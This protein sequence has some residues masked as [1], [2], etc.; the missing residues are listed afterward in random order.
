MDKNEV[1]TRLNNSDYS[2]EFWFLNQLVWKIPFNLCED[3]VFCKKNLFTSLARYIDVLKKEQPNWWENE[4]QSFINSI[5]NGSL[6]TGLD[7]LKNIDSFLCK[8][9]LKRFEENGYSNSANIVRNS[10]ENEEYLFKLSE[11]WKTWSAI[12]WISPEFIP[13]RYIEWSMNNWLF[14]EIRNENIKN[15]IDVFTQKK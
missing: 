12:T 2:K 1:E 4:I 5:I 13:D 15:I 7:L 3:A 11:N 8:K 9:K 6:G 10:L 14:N